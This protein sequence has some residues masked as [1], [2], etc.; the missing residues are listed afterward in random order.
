M[1]KTHVYT[2]LWPR[3][4]LNIC[5]KRPVCPACNQRP[6]AVNYHRD[7][8]AH[9]R[10]RCESCIRKNRGIKPREPRWKS[11]G[12]KKKMACDRCGFRARYSAQIM[13]YHI[14]GNLNHSEP[15]N[16]RCICRNC[17]IDVAKGDL[18]WRPGDLE[19]DS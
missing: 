11:S 1:P 4:K 14:D 9:Y 10:S 15:K 2:A 7:G 5:M 8:V 3:S 16:L 6:C 19:P 17:E 12:Y 13:V 18:V